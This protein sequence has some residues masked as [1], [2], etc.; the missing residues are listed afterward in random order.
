MSPLKVGTRVNVIGWHLNGAVISEPARITR[1]TKVMGTRDSLPEGYEPV[2]F[3]DGAVL[4]I[5][6]TR[7]QICSNA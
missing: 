1:W 2:R 6:R 7:M 3:A 5:H 4:M